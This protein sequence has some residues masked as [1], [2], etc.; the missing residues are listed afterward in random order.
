MPNGNNL[1][2]CYIERDHKVKQ[3]VS[4]VRTV[5]WATS[6]ENLFQPYENNKGADQPAHPR[7]LIS[8]FV[9]R[10]LE[11]TEVGLFFVFRYSFSQK[12]VCFSLFIFRYSL[13]EVSLFFVF[14][15]SFSQKLVCFSLFVF[16]YSLS[17]VS[18]FFVICFSLF[19]FRFSTFGPCPTI[20]FLISKI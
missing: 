12:L 9:V 8:A 10:C 11:Q 5:T 6:W 15:Y 13:S 16:R 18:L 3:R 7:S 20:K 14:R 19:V 4:N 17:E 2:T 1:K